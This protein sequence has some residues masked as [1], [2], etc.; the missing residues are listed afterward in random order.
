MFRLF[1]YFLLV[2]GLGFLFAWVA[3]RPGLVALDWQ[4]QRY[5][6]SL[7]VAVSALV[8][9]LAAILIVWGAVRGVLQSPGLLSRFFKNRRRDRGYAALSQ[10]MIA[11]SSGNVVKARKLAK[12]SGRL[13][14]EEPMVALLDAQ[15]SLLEGKRE[16][17]RVQYAKMLENENT[18]LLA[19]RGLYLEAEREGAGEAARHYAKEAS[20]LEPALPWAGEAML[21]F[22]ATDKDWEAA[23]E[24][25]ESNRSAGLIEKQA[26]TL[27]RAVLL[28][29]QAFQEELANPERSAKLAQ[30]AHKLDPQLVPAAVIG[31]RAYTRIG[32]I[33]RASKIIE[34]VWRQN[35]HP[36]LA[37][38][39]T[40]VRSGDSVLDRLKRARHLASLKAHHPESNMAIALAALDAN[41]WKTAREVMQSVIT[42]N[43]TERACLIM[44]DIEEGEHGDKGRMRD[45]LARAIRAPRDKVWTADGYVS[46]EWMPLSPITGKVGAFEWKLPVEQ[47]GESPDV[48]DVSDLAEPLGIDPQKSGIEPDAATAA[49]SSIAATAATTNVSEPGEPENPGDQT[50]LDATA[51]S[52]TQAD[53]GDEPGEGRA[54]PDDVIEAE[55]IE[56]K[57]PSEPAADAP[58]QPDEA[59][60]QAPTDPALAESDSAQ[61]NAEDDPASDEDGDDNRVEFPLKHRPDDPGVDPEKVPEKKKF[62]LF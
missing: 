57:P 27:Q 2:L 29:A 45:W 60:E 12:E 22:H 10:G 46:E 44:A 14:N 41:D 58:Q 53:G 51:E 26:A 47:L 11:A 9:L 43:L 48:I 4:G 7:M 62:K 38:A 54:K 28:T 15:T 21:R 39:Y 52:A 37:E 31:A 19:L 13:L 42:N 3:D 20:A 30:Q 8:G 55:I 61:E 34:A 50:A 35:P 36:E 49:V 6:T 17:A 59:S 23:L 40:H 16:N 24:R 56:L 33:K 25:L 32:D 1:L 18:K 5:E